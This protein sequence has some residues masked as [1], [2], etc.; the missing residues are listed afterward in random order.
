MNNFCQQPLLTILTALAAERKILASRPAGD[1]SIVQC[2]MGCESAYKKASGL[3]GQTILGSI[4][5]SGAMALGLA[6]GTVIL[7]DNICTQCLQPAYLQR[8]YRLNVALVDML[9][10]VLNEQ[11]IG[12]RRGMVLC[13]DEPLLT[14]VDK[15]KAHGRTG[16]LA[17]DME[18]AAVAE[19]ALQKGTPF[20]CLRVICD[21]AWR[22]LEQALLAGIDNRGNSRPFHLVAAVCRRPRLVGSLVRMAGD[23]SRA[24]AGMARAWE[25]IRQPLLD[26][27]ESA[28]RSSDGHGQGL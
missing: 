9:E 22:G 18:S 10:A 28:A 23:F 26:F 1:I 6:P 17:V 3:V 8:S 5:V 7:A 2:G 24:A 12:Y 21:P 4:G 27:V 14:P 25:V 11:G 13:V 16:A 15:A 20:F 19:A